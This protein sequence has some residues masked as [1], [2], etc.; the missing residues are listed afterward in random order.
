MPIIRKY[1]RRPYRSLYTRKRRGA[2]NRLM[3]RRKR[4]KPQLSVVRGVSA[5][6]DETMVKLKYTQ[7]YNVSTGSNI[8]N[9][10]YR[11]NGPFD[12]EVAVG[13]GQPPMYDTYT[14][15]YYRYDCR[16]CRIKATLLPT[17]NTVAAS[18]IVWGIIPTN[19][20][21][22]SYTLGDIIEQPLSKWK[23]ANALYGAGR[24]QTIVHY[25][26]TQKMK[27]LRKGQLNDDTYHAD[28]SST[29]I[30]QW[31]WDVLVSSADEATVPICNI[32][33]ELTY[34]VRFY[35]RK[36]ITDA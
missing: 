32:V 20:S 36:V 34:Y 10:Q 28:T 18:S 22:Y 4:N 35:N 11:G 13:G 16:G 14:S 3:Y 5:F 17:T 12:P 9:V 8:D 6:P 24:N 15:M 19:D 23:T 26:S 2:R 21:S 33:V 7:I 30:S 1:P 25:M 31:Y 29:P 27:G